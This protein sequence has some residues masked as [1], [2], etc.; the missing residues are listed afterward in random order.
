MTNF[1]WSLP[2]G[3]SSTPGEEDDGPCK[4]CG[5]DVGRCICLECHICGEQGN[6]DCYQTHG[7]T[8]RVEQIKGLET[9]LDYRY[10]DRNIDRL[11]FHGLLA[12]NKGAEE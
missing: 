2:P 7:L 1:G 5:L 6:S 8:L 10:Q 3:C 12:Y 9:L 4:V 11:Y